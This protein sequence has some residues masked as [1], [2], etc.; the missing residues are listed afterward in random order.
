MP[1]TERDIDTEIELDLPESLVDNLTYLAKSYGL[2]L[3][4]VMKVALWVAEDKFHH[5]K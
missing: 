4:D 1:D 3:G 2:S 5:E